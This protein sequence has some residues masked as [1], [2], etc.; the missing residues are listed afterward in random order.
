MGDVVAFGAYPDDVDVEAVM[1]GTSVKLVEKGISLLFVDLCHG[2]P[3][4]HTARGER[5]KQALKAA[6]ILGVER[7]T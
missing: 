2:E 1:C 4:R 3:A 7:A 6:E 5:H